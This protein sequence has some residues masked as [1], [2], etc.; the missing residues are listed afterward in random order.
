LQHAFEQLGDVVF[1]ELPKFGEIVDK[2]VSAAVI[3][4]VIAVS[5]IYSA[6]SD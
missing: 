1:I 2:A 3:G 4:S 5:Y 6:A